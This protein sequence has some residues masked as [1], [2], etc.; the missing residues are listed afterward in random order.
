[1]DETTN[2]FGLN[3]GFVKFGHSEKWN[4]IKIPLNLAIST[5]FLP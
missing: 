3:H 1:M 5:F 4:F 2:E